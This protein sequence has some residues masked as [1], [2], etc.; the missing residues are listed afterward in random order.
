MMEFRDSY[1]NIQGWM[2]TDLKLT[3]NELITYAVIYG[4]CRDGQ[5]WYKL[6][7]EHVAR[8][9]G[10]TTRG[11]R[12]ILTNLK[13]KGLLKMRND[14]SGGCS[15]YMTIK[16]DRLP[17][18]AELSSGEVRNSVPEVRNS[19]PGVRNSVPEGAELSSYPTSNN[20][21]NNIN[22]INNI[23]EI[24]KEKQLENDFEELW[25]LYPKK[26]GKTEAFNDYKK[27]IK[28]GTTNEEIKQGI[29]NLIEDIRKNKT[30]DQFIPYG[31]TYFHK[32]RWTDEISSGFKQKTCGD[33]KSQEFME[34]E[35]F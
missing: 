28:A 35:P 27:A 2:I 8:W 13:E 16:P 22:N 23:K 25:K 7:Q 31:S 3:G 33:N 12:K 17:D 5:N 11:L 9:S 4:F 24:T 6:S 30:E 20:I 15:E 1:C 32:K 34:S 19:V 29:L 26:R 18:S 10:I 21:N 14:G